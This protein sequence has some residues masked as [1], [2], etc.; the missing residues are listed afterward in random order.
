MV[1]RRRDHG[2][3]WKDLVYLRARM[4]LPPCGRREGQ[5]RA[6]RQVGWKLWCWEDR[7]VLVKLCLFCQ[8][9]RSKVFS[10][11]FG[12]GEGC[13][14]ISECER[15]N[16]VGKSRRAVLIMNLRFTI[17]ELVRTP[18]LDLSC[19]LSWTESGSCQVG[20]PRK[21]TERG[22]WMVE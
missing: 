7:A 9:L 22:A 19:G 16:R 21:K 14:V 20:G 10:S 4:L 1:E 12:R 3:K 18:L 6:E 15:A 5:A 11:E 17:V 8:R 2:A 13:R